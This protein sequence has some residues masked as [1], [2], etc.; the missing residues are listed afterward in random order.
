MTSWRIKTGNQM[1]SLVWRAVCFKNNFMR[2]YMFLFA[3]KKFLFEIAS[4]FICSLVYILLGQ[5]VSNEKHHSVRNSVFHL[6]LRKLNLA[7]NRNMPRFVSMLGNC[8][9]LSTSKPYVSAMFFYPFTHWSPCFA[10]IHFAAYT[11]DLVNNTI[12]FLDTTV[13]RNSDGLL[14]TTVYRKPTHTDQYLAYDY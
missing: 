12:P 8:R 1:H 3:N 4:I 11:W 7:T 14:T 6:K 2:W 10:D 5:F 13:K 9:G